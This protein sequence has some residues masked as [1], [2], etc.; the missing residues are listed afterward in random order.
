MIPRFK[1]ISFCCFLGACTLP[2][3]KNKNADWSEYNGGPDKNHYSALA[4]I[5]KENLSNLE[6]AW[7]YHS[8]GADTVNNRTQ[9]QCNPV[10]IDGIM[11][12]VSADSQAF[13]VQADNGK[14]LWKTTIRDETFS[15]TS[16]G[17]TYF[18]NKGKPIIFFGYGEWL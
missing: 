13:A 17:V 12:G 11:Y 14:E 5:N 6:V 3:T 7:V 10:I 9:M 16:R 8:G 15:M 4:E 1:S 18:A 2:S